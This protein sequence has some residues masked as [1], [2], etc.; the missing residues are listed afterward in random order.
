MTIIHTFLQMV[1]K[2]HEKF[3][4]VKSERLDSDRSSLDR[5]SDA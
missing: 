2:T 4:K 3:D 5:L 1:E